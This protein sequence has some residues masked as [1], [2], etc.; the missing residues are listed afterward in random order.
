MGILALQT[1]L[2]L[3]AAVQCGLASALH[4]ASVEALYNEIVC[5]HSSGK[6]GL[7]TARAAKGR[8]SSTACPTLHC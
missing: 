2:A 7:K 5:L 8:L 4:G 6:S 1:R 3:V